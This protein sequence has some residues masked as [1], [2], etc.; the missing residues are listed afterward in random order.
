MNRMPKE[1][2]SVPVTRV[3]LVDHGRL[4]QNPRFYPLAPASKGQFFHTVRLRQA[5]TEDWFRPGRLVRPAR[6][7][8]R[9]S[10]RNRGMIL[11]G[12][13]PENYAT[14]NCQHVLTCTPYTGAHIHEEL[15]SSLACETYA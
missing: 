14:N 11:H 13:F 15:C 10:R 6:E 5:P 3:Y 2:A 4:C 9:K 7:E 12:D 1:F 8:I